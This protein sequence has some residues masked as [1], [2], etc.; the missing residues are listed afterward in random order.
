M[1]LQAKMVEMVRLDRE[2][3]RGHRVAQEARDHR[4]TVETEEHRVHQDPQVPLARPVDQE[5]PV[6][7]EHPVSTDRGE[8][9]VPRGHPV[10]W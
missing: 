3:L 1:A 2:V 7:Q 10:N 5:T 6:T 9:P 8:T 4:E